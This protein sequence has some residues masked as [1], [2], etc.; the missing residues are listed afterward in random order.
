MTQYTL[1]DRPRFT[2]T[3]TSG[4]VVTDPTKITVTITPR[5]TTA[6]TYT[7]LLAGGGDAA[8]VHDSTGVVHVDWPIAAYGAHVVKFQSF[9]GSNAS[10]DVTETTF[11]AVN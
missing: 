11:F 2:Y 3:F 5:D 7:W 10:L 6:T 4:G 9:D 1:G 8:L